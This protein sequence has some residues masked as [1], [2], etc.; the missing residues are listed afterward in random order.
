[1]WEAWVNNCDGTIKKEVG[2]RFRYRR[3][4]DLGSVSTEGQVNDATDAD[5]AQRQLHLCPINDRDLVQPEIDGTKVTSLYSFVCSGAEQYLDGTTAATT[6]EFTLKYCEKLFESEV[7]Y[8]NTQAGVAVSTTI[9][10][11]RAE[12]AQLSNKKE[13]VPSN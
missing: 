12:L 5:W 13:Y 9:I 11:A 1:M 3:C 8:C 2:N 6:T 4:K 7:I 10:Q